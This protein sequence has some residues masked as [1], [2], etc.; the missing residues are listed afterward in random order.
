MKVSETEDDACALPVLREVIARAGAEL[1]AS[2]ARVEMLAGGYTPQHLCR[3]TLEDERK[4]VLKT[5]GPNGDAPQP[6]PVWT[7]VLRRE[8]GFYREQPRLRRWQPAFFGGFEQDDWVGLLLEDLSEA[9][10]V[11]PWNADAIHATARGLAGMHAHTLGN[12]ERDR[13]AVRDETLRVFRQIR[14]R[15]RSAGNLPPECDTHE[16][17]AWLG[18][19][20]EAGERT[21]K[22]T[23][24]DGPHCLIHFD[25]RSDNLF[26]R[27]GELLLIDWS[28]AAWRTP[29]LDSVYWALGVEVEGGGLAPEVH[30]TYLAHAPFRSE[31]DVKRSIAFCAAFFVNG[32]QAATAPA[33]VQAIR[34]RI[35]GP[36]LRW[37]ADE[38]ALSPPPLT[39]I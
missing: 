28:S 25:V 22:D 10:R 31:R 2:V 7:E 26:L 38:C 36:T 23:L 1:G 19:A 5:V 24:D 9:V 20:V 39:G 32:L 16:W 15:G 11:P 8:V 3:L 18:L 33:A 27:D 17:W 29:F 12:S 4:A 14:E 13:T 30:K 21:F 6:S 35:L 34:R 37:F